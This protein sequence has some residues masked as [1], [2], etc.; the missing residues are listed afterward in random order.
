MKNLPKRRHKTKEVDQF[1]GQ[2]LMITQELPEYGDAYLP[3]PIR[4]DRTMGCIAGGDRK[5]CLR[6]QVN[7]LV[8]AAAFLAS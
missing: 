5:A 2:P 3:P 6:V 1:T 4:K 7:Y 8:S